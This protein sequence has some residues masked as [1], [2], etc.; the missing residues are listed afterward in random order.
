MDLIPLL[1]LLQSSHKDLV[2]IG[3]TITRVYELIIL[4]PELDLEAITLD[5]PRLDAPFL[6]K[7]EK[8][9]STWTANLHIRNVTHI[10]K[11]DKVIGNLVKGPNGPAILTAH[12]D[13]LAVVN[14][15]ALCSAL[16]ELA[17]YLGNSWIMDLARGVAA[18]TPCVNSIHSRIAL[19]SQGGGKTRIIAIGDY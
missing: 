3:L 13:A 6:T 9:C 2:R 1:P 12:Y 10:P 18:N 15:S 11:L 4:P 7:F 5:G 19:L 14:D 16:D 17:A 8:F